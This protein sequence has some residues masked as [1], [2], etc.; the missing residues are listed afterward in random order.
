M[1]YF[2]KSEIAGP[3][4]CLLEKTHKLISAHIDLRGEVDKTFCNADFA[5]LAEIETSFPISS[6]REDRIL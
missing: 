5:L 6:H 3:C 2:L 1:F 4:L